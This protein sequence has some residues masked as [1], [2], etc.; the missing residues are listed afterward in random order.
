M[1]P[2]IWTPLINSMTNIGFSDIDI[3][4]TNVTFSSGICGN[5]A[6]VG[7]GLE[8]P[9]LD[10]DIVS[11]GFSLSMF[12]KLTAGMTVFKY[13]AGTKTLM[14]IMIDSMNMAI[15]YDTG[16]GEYVTLFVMD[17][18][19]SVGKWISFVYTY[20]GNNSS[21]VYINGN[22]IASS[23][24]KPFDVDINDE[25]KFVFESCELFNLK[26]YVGVI[27]MRQIIDDYCCLLVGYKFDGSGLTE[28]G[29]TECDYS[30]FLNDARFVTPV[31]LTSTSSPVRP[32]SEIIKNNMA[33]VSDKS[34]DTFFVNFWVYPVA[35]I[36]ESQVIFKYG[37]LLTVTVR[38][39]SSSDSVTLSIIYSA[40]DISTPTYH[41]TIQFSNWYMVSL[42]HDSKGFRAYINCEKVI[43]A[44]DTTSL[45]G[46]AF[47]L[48]TFNGA[49]SDFR[50]YLRTPSEE[51][52]TWLYRA[53]TIMDD[54]GTLCAGNV[55]EVEDAKQ[56]TFNNKDGFTSS[57]IEVS[58]NCSN[59][60]KYDTVNKVL[61]IKDFIEF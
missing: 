10:D 38:Y 8:Y 33:M 22:Y 58:E 5:N 35:T 21:S 27:S 16:S 7:T 18:H 36:T 49:Y 26:I 13:Q 42:L 59:A 44:I 41:K 51:Y 31:V 14:G 19:D 6:I 32:Y 52:I 30:G 39:N 50:L 56:L 2:I 57:S 34:W 37:T 20:D 12:V 45:S 53:S 60:M 24:I 46:S 3:D 25:K 54:K 1:Y 61:T 4:G 11:K 23:D 29:L 17:C 47:T 43:D 28:D 48:C 9:I 15:K 40:S 55:T